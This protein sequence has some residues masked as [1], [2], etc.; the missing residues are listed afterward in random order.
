M[1]LR[2]V[3][4]LECVG[5]NPVALVEG[6]VKCFCLEREALSHALCVF[7]SFEVIPCVALDFVRVL[8]MSLDVACIV[9]HLALRPN[10]NRRSSCY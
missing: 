4:K 3:W 10:D 8:C 9:L 5:L 1:D 6:F 7:K 2:S